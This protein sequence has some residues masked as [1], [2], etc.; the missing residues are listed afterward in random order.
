MLG[1]VLAR[2]I[3]ENRL[4]GSVYGE[5]YA[6]GAG[7]SL[8]LLYWEYVSKLYLN[9][10]DPCIYAVWR[11]ILDHT[12][13]FCKR[14]GDVPLSID[15]WKKQ[16]TIYTNYGQNSTLD[17]GFATFY[18][19]RT[20]RSGIIK[21][22]GPIGGYDQSGPWKIDARFSRT[23]LI[24][25]IQRIALYRERIAFTAFDAISFCKSLPSLPK[26]FLY[27]DPPY[28]VKGSELYLNHYKDSDHR[29]LAA[30]LKAR[31]GMNWVLTYDRVPE[32]EKLYKGFPRIRFSLSYS[33]TK[34][35]IGREL[36]ILSKSVRVPKP[37]RK[38]L[39][40]SAI[41]LGRV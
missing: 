35:K 41:R 13:E 12:E 2:I 19:N 15:E 14:I 40:K 1:S 18:L 33:A 8:S 7:A 36:L 4:E 30:F 11:S 31:S 27:L 22:G 17:V 29:E 34:R 32:I 25:R 38:R 10:A 21:N 24:E 16:K 28:Y 6:G 9:D 3:T 39:P 37:W 26:L 5:P 20:N 23:G